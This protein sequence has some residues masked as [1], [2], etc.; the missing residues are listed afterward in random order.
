MLLCLLLAALL[1]ELS[2]CTAIFCTVCCRRTLTYCLALQRCFCV[3]SLVPL[4]TY[5]SVDE[6]VER[7][8][9]Y[10]HCLALLF[11][12]PAADLPSR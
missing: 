5:A 12:L 6:Y 3:C 11:R 2:L 4:Q 1:I 9:C 10:A 8:L 7:L